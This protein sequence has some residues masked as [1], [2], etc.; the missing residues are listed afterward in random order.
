MRD[1]SD[2]G[3]SRRRFL[4]GT[5]LGLGGLSVLAVTPTWALKAAGS[6]PAATHSDQ[7]IPTLEA[8]LVAYIH[9]AAKGEVVLMVGTKEVVRKDRAL[10][11]R[12]VQCCEV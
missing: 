10:V 12:L 7:P 5:A 2:P 11:S 6:G 8:P 4:K 3:L 9:D 1:H